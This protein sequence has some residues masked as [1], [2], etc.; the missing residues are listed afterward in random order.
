MSDEVFANG[1]EVSCKSASGKSICAFPDVCFTPPTTPA[2]PPGV[3]IPYP[4]TGMASDCTSGS[5]SVKISGQEIMLKDKSY[6]KRSTGDEAGCAPKKGVMTSVN[7]GKVY[8]VAWS[9]DVHV[10]GEN[11]VRH[12]DMTTHNHA[13]Y[14][15]NT[16]PWPYVHKL[17]MNKGGACHRDGV[18]EQKACEDFTPHGADDLCESLKP[19][20]Y[21]PKPLF[22]RSGKPSGEKSSKQALSLAKHTAANACMRARRCFLMPYVPKSGTKGCCSP[23]TGHHL[24]EAS[25]LFD[26]GRGGAGSTPLVGVNSGPRKYDEN[27]APCVCAEGKNQNS[28]SHGWM[29]TFQSREAAKQPLGTLKLSG[30]KGSI[31]NVRTQSYKKAKETARKAMKKVFPGSPC[32]KDC[33]D[34]QL[35][36]YHKQCGVTDSTKI[37]AVE[38]GDTSPE[39]VAKAEQ[40]I[41]ACLKAGK[42]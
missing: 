16:A 22:K 13:S 40:G 21:K 7:M 32:S 4:N 17:S 28:G 24:V 35:D 34:K 41:A 8:F 1:M 27:D 23:Q 25:S 9:M 29:H 26:S 3:P 36:N 15:S 18:R 39:A 6:F 19:L 33:I 38:E 20:P 10:E 5:T 12:F 30:N 37:K 11:V 14:P 31:N 42:S 2:T